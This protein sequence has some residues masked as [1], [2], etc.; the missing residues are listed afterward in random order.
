MQT[1]SAVANSR[2]KHRPDGLSAFNRSLR[3]LMID[4][5]VVVEFS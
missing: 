2:S 5:I 1:I 3:R 4:R